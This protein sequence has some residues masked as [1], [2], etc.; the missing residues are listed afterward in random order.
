MLYSLTCQ[1]SCS[2]FAVLGSKKF[3]F[4]FVVVMLFGFYFRE[5]QE[6]KVKKALKEKKALQVILGYLVTKAI[7][8]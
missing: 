7:Q 6:S 2:C 5:S 4:Y 1:L 8:D 3:A